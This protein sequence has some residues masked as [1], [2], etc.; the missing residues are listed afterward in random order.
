MF[1]VAYTVTEHVVSFGFPMFDQMGR[2]NLPLNPF[3][4]PPKF[5]NK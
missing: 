1:E 3:G 5:W 2:T 4:L